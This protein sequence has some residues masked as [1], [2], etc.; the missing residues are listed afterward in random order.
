MIRVCS[1]EINLPVLSPKEFKM[2]C[3][4]KQVCQNNSNYYNRIALYKEMTVFF[5]TWILIQKKSNCKQLTV[6]GSKRWL[7]I[8]RHI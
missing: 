1:I 8:K 6:L 5:Y 2:V 7:G 4:H 3:F